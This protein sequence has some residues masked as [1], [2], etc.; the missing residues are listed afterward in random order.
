MTESEMDKAKQAV[1]E[2]AREG[3]VSCKQLLD[4]AQSTGLSSAS[5]GRACNE[6]GVKIHACQLGCFK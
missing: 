2:V 5:L 4:L 6:L 3:K 1:R